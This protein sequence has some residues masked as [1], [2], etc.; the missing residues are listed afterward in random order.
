VIRLGN[1][2]ELVRAQNPALGLYLFRLVVLMVEAALP[3]DFEGNWAKGW[4]TGSRLQ[5]GGVQLADLLE[6]LL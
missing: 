4:L 3:R 5:P 1:V 2:S 6:R